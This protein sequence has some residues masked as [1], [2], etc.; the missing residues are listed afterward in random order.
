MSDGDIHFDLQ[1]IEAAR[2]AGYVSTSTATAGEEGERLVA[3]LAKRTY[4]PTPYRL[5]PYVY[6]GTEGCEVMVLP[7]L[8]WIRVLTSASRA[9]HLFEPLLD[10]AARHGERGID[11]LRA[12]MSLGTTGPEK[13]ASVEAVLAS[14]GLYTAPEAAL[15]GLYEP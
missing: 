15:A 6:D 13:I 5:V 3:L 4:D 12:L 10:Y 1:H 8:R 14:E 2:A 9:S 7:W 11:T